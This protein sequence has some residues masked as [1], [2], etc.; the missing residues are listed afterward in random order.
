MKHA[1][2]LLPLG[3]RSFMFLRELFAVPTYQENKA[4]IASKVIFNQ[5]LSINQYIESYEDRYELKLVTYFNTL[6]IDNPNFDISEIRKLLWNAWST[7]YALNISQDVDEAEYYKFALH[8][9]FPQAYYSVY[10]AMTA[11]HETQGKSANNH[12]KSIK[13]FGNSIKDGHYPAP[14]SF[15]CCGLHNE[16]EYNSLTEL[17]TIDAGFEVLARVETNRD[18]ENHIAKFLKSTRENEAEKQKDKY[19]K[20]PPNDDFK[21]IT[22]SPRKSYRKEHWDFIY[23][24]APVTSILNLLYRLRIRANY[25]DIESFMNANIDFEEFHENLSGIVYYL[26]FVHE[27]YIAKC[28]GSDEYEKILRDFPSHLNKDTAVARFEECIEPLLNK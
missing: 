3:K 24:K 9:N 10:L 12:D 4:S 7:E 15:Y 11:F 14:I 6:K 13:V 5:F 22:G 16:F 21:T 26:N 20:Q 23:R 18:Y 17:V 19:I 28:I 1:L 8:W 2:Y 25:Q 27:A